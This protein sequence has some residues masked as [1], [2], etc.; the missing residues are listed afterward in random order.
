SEVDALPV[1]C[2]FPDVFPDDISDLPP[3]REVEFAVDVLPG[4]RGDSAA[5]QAWARAWAPKY[6]YIF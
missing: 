3:E 2:E 6:I 1:V 4:T 5:Q